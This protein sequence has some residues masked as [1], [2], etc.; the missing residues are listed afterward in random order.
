MS[1]LSTPY[2]FVPA[3]PFVLSPEWAAQASHDHPFEDGL[4]GEL[5]I[6][7]VNRTPLCVGGKQEAATEYAAGKVSIYRTP[8]NIPAI[9]GSSLKGMLRNVLAP[10]VFARMG[11]VEDRKLSVR[12]INS[13]DTYYAQT[14][15]RQKQHAGWLRFHEG[16][17][18]IKG[19][20]Y[21]RIFQ[22]DIITHFKLNESKWKKAKT[23]SARYELL[24]GFK[25]VK[26]NTQP[27]KYNRI[28]TVDLGKGELSGKLVVTGQPGDAYNEGKDGGRKSKKWEFVFYEKEN[29]P[30]EWQAVPVD[31]LKDFLFV[32][33]DGKEWEFFLKN[34]KTY[35]EI[36]VFYHLTGGQ[37]SSMGLALMYRLAQKNSL[38]NA[39]N[40]ISPQHLNAG[41]ADFTELLFGRMAPEG[42]ENPVHD[43]SLRGR[44][45]IGL[46]EA[47]GSPETEWTDETVLSS[48]KPSFFPAYLQQPE[49]NKSGN[50]VLA[51]L[52]SK[53]PKLSGWKRYPVKPKHIQPPP[54]Q[55]EGK[56]LSNK[57]KVRLETLKPDTRFTGKIR[58]HN[59]RP[60]ELGALLWVLDFGER[61]N[62]CHALGM[63]KPYGLG[64]VQISVKNE[65]CKVVANNRAALADVTT[66]NTLVAARRLFIAYMDDVWQNVTQVQTNKVPS[67]EESE[68]V[69]N[70]LAMANPDNG[71]HQAAYLKYLPEPKAFMRVKQAPAEY[72]SPYVDTNEVLWA[73]ENIKEPLVV[74]ATMT[75]EQGLAKLN[76]E[77]RAKAEQQQKAQERLE[78]GPVERLLDDLNGFIT[79]MEETGGFKSTPKTIEKHLKQVAELE[80]SEWLE[81]VQ[82]ESLLQQLEALLRR[83]EAIDNKLVNKAAKKARARLEAA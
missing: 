45:N 40:N 83:A 69:R 32:H 62:L 79:Q 1:N 66:E 73:T 48:P 18:Q 13:S 51:T 34:S 43:W 47:T 80:E 29:N 71:E 28:E 72:L 25:N 30:Q 44:V 78:M 16:Q 39:L 38:H 35:T 56:A 36:P 74:Q 20:E 55:E 59:L 3:A 24:E 67:W 63:G 52:D 9:A 27:G 53:N 61:D 8:E 57:V 7:L 33:Q 58:F 82:D 65:A 54:Q 37:I 42:I 14:I 49:S 17:W 12:D 4:S 5:T 77:A 75:L 15:V 50:I 68:Q 64:Q 19:C 2:N 76:E 21:A 10:V 41:Q 11:Q 70:V 31:T 81:L 23:A 26:F 6:E 22:G 46:L 60:V